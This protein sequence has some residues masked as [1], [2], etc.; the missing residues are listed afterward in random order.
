MMNKIV[1]LVAMLAV[2]ALA[3]AKSYSI[4]LFEPSVIGGIELKPGDYTLELKDEKVVIRKGKQIGEAP[5][6]VESAD[7]KYSST[8]VRY[9]NGDGRY[10][11]QEIHLGGTNMKLIVNV[12]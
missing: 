2:A 8:T 3:S 1:V 10:H 12:E 11:I 6:K 5:V 9:S 7:T 4:K